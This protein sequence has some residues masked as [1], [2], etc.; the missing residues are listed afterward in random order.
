MSVPLS[1]C[2][3]DDKPSVW[4]R[5]GG[6]DRIGDDGK[7]APAEACD[8]GVATVLDAIDPTPPGPRADGGLI[9]PT[10]MSCNP[11]S[12]CTGTRGQ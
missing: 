3:R 10:R 8:G 6:A 4:Y 2:L 5:R 1:S 9:S 11:P 12:P 7:G